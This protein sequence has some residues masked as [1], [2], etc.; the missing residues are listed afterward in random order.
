MIISRIDISLLGR[1]IHEA[2]DAFMLIFLYYGVRQLFP[3][4]RSG[5]MAGLVNF[6]QMSAIATGALIFAPIGQNYGNILP[7]LIGT[8][9]CIIALVLAHR[10][11]SLIKH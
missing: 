9:L 6:V 8:G 4:E 10:F 1:F 7:F 3:S 5:G 11:S 2:G